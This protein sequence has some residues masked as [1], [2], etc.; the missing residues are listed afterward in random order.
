MPIT[1]SIGGGKVQEENLA[2][3]LLLVAAQQDG[4]SVQSV[5]SLVERWREM[6]R[7][8]KKDP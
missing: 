4:S 2:A 7:G 8:L 6:K 3:L 5:E 1:P